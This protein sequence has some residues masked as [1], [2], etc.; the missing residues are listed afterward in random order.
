MWKRLFVVCAVVVMVEQMPV[1]LIVISVLVEERMV[2]YRRVLFLQ[3]LK[4]CS[5]TYLKWFGKKGDRNRF[6]LIK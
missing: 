4:V 3:M 6:N 5:E 1:E 2:D